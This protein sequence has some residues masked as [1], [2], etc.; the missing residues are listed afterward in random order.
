M[1]SGEHVSYRREAIAEQF[2]EPFK[3]SALLFLLRCDQRADVVDDHHLRLA[4]GPVVDV[5]W[6]GIIGEIGLRRS[7]RE[8]EQGIEAQI[9]NFGALEGEFGTDPG[10]ERSAAGPNG[11]AYDY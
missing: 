1:A 6:T 8:F 11:A 9:A 5:D 3:I 10:R 4:P 7:R 2:L